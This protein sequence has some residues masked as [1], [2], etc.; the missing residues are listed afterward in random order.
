MNQDK[1]IYIIIGLL[2]IVVILLLMV[3]QQVSKPV[4]DLLQKANG[5]IAGCSE[6]VK[7]WQAQHP[8]SATI[9]DAARTDLLNI[10]KDCSA[11]VGS[12]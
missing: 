6:A 8:S 5:N 4:T 10:L 2:I 3:L 11:K 1:H 12:N 9:D 7:N